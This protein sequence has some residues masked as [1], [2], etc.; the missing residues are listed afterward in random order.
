M[1]AGLRLPSSQVPRFEGIREL[2]RMAGMAAVGSLPGGW[3]REAF[4]SSCMNKCDGLGFYSAH[5]I[6]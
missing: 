4:E 6:F 3:E 5:D 2:H 1:G